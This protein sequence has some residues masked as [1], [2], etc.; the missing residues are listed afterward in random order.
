LKI[1]VSC[2]TVATLGHHTTASP[3]ELDETM[4]IT[5]NNDLNNGISIATQPSRYRSSLE[6]RM[7]YAN[8]K[9]KNNPEADVNIVP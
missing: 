8:T 6:K 4:L 1:G 3:H 7:A 5:I 2:E 9:T